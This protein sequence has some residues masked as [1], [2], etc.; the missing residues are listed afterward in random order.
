LTARQRWLRP[1]I[2]DDQLER[3]VM[4]FHDASDRSAH[5]LRS[6]SNRDDH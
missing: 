6:V 4:L 1:V 2:D 3:A 5:L